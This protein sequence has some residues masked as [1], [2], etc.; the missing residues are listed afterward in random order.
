MN[1]EMLKGLLSSLGFVVFGI[2]IIAID[3]RS[4]LGVAIGALNIAFGL[5]GFVA[6]SIGILRGPSQ[7]SHFHTRI[8]SDIIVQRIPPADEEIEEVW[9]HSSPTQPLLSVEATK[10]KEVSE[11]RWRIEVH[12]AEFT[13][14]P[15]SDQILAPATYEALKNTANVLEVQREDTEAWIVSGNPSGRELVENVG[16]ALAKCIPSVVPLLWR[17]QAGI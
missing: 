6:I 10:E 5:F 11:Y 16:A 1:R 8:P 12:L 2:L 4:S 3:T 9:L 17:E 15:G 14:D 7:S 13:R